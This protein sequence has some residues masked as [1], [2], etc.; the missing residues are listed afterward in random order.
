ME[1][2]P[3]P[4]AESDQAS[5]FTSCP[6]EKLIIWSNKTSIYLFFWCA[7]GSEGSWAAIHHPGCSLNIK[8]CNGPV[9][10]SLQ[11]LPITL[12]NYS[13]SLGVKEKQ[14]EAKPRLWNKHVGWHL[15]QER[16]PGFVPGARPS[17]REL[18]HRSFEGED[19]SLSFLTLDQLAGC[20]VVLIIK[21]WWRQQEWQ[22]ERFELATLFLLPQH[23]KVSH[24]ADGT[25]SRHWAVVFCSRASCASAQSLAIV[26]LE[27]AF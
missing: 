5:N 14:G 6:S 13:W 2:I 12:G 7:S 25:Q 27:T 22:L 16:R 11:S 18:I 23:P 10:L 1:D 17:S 3:K 20:D 4:P 9:L 24:L 15:S 19:F 8:G 26:K 21:T